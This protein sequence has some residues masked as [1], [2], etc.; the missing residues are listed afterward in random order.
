M[1]FHWLHK[2]MTHKH[3][4]RYWQPES[5]YLVDYYTKHHTVIY[6]KKIREIIYHLQISIHAY[7]QKLVRVS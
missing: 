4:Q 5:T 7:K 3:L 1:R 2:K 6:H